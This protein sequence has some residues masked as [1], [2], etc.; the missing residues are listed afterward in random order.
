MNSVLSVPNR[1]KTHTHTHT[2]TPKFIHSF[3]QQ[4]MNIEHVSPLL[5]AHCLQIYHI[6]ILFHCLR[7][8]RVDSLAISLVARWLLVSYRTRL[9]KWFIDILFPHFFN[10]E[11]LFDWFLIRFY[12]SILNHLQCHSDFLYFI[13]DEAMVWCWLVA[14]RLGFELYFKMLV[15]RCVNFQNNKTCKK[16]HEM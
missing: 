6:I 15:D 2:K 8:N 13:Y 1:N 16:L 10:F 9:A 12:F 4:V 3:E 14:W 5:I 11:N 7:L